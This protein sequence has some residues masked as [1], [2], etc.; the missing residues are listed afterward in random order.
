[1]SAR[2][3]DEPRRQGPGP[4][5]SQ[6]EDGGLTMGLHRQTA[7]MDDPGVQT[8][9]R[10]HGVG[11][12][13][14]PVDGFKR[15]RRLDIRAENCTGILKNGNCDGDPFWMP[16]DGAWYNW[17]G[18]G[19]TPS[20]RKGGTIMNQANPG[21]PNGYDFA[22]G[23]STTNVPLANWNAPQ[24]TAYAVVSDSEL[25]VVRQRSI[26]G[27]G[28]GTGGPGDDNYNCY[29]NCNCN[30]ACACAC[31]CDCQ[32]DCCFP[33]GTPVTMADGTQRDIALVQP[34]DLVKGA[35]GLINRVDRMFVGRIGPH[36]AFLI[37]GRY[38]VAGAHRVW[39]LARGWVAADP[40]SWYAAMKEPGSLIRFAAVH[41][42]AEPPADGIYAPESERPKQ[43]VIGDRL[44]WGSLDRFL[45]V[46]HIEP[47]HHDGTLM[48]YEP[49]CHNGSGSYEV[50]GG[51]W[52]VAG[53]DYAFPFQSYLQ[54]EIQ[55]DLGPAAQLG[56]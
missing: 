28:Q 47:I 12:S 49:I 33:A 43:M 17:P 44:A 54:Q 25:V 38:F 5:A 35:F 2:G 37:N 1:M 4:A 11:P 45:V 21:N 19:G 56:P 14:R 23:Q 7:H 26:T 48:L 52:A 8:H 10:L 22:G 9:N 41:G 46:E 30:C 15:E 29:A 24:R 51:L 18:I 53:P 20:N 36:S 16:P 27:F 39:S 55:H 3:G 32:C 31:A 40:A 34:G 13:R 42:V 50:Y 6:A